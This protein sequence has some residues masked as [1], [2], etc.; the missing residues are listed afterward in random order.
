[1]L[2]RSGGINY[3]NEDFIKAADD[4][5]GAG[6]WAL[7][8]KHFM[9]G[10][11]FQV[12]HRHQGLLSLKDTGDVVVRSQTG[13]LLPLRG[14]LHATAQMNL[15]WDNSPA[16]GTKKTDTTYLLKVGYGW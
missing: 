15:D 9:F 2:F 8:F 6:R 13:L 16:P 7:D 10:R 11:L 1:M 4:S 12:F 5:Y 3:V 14:G